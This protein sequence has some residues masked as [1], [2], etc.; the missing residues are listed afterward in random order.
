MNVPD[1]LTGSVVRAGRMG[2]P[3]PQVVTRSPAEGQPRL[4][5]RQTPSQGPE[6]RG[7]LEGAEV[8]SFPGS[9]MGRE[10]WLGEMGC[11]A[12]GRRAGLPLQTFNLRAIVPPRSAQHAG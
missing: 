8:H 3:L 7:A 2:C 9:K 5:E 1:G 11:L 12:Q 10:A 4:G 6:E